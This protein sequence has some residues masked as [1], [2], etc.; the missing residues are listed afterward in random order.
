MNYFWLVIILAQNT[1]ESFPKTSEGECFA[2]LF[3][4]HLTHFFPFFS[5][6][7]Q[8]RVNVEVVRLIS[9]RYEALYLEGC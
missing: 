2:F 4:F 3:S 9:R 8:L 6:Q 5:S 1:G 7:S